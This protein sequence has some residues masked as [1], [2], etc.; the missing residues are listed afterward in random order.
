[1][2][3]AKRL[4]PSFPGKRFHFVLKLVICQVPINSWKF[5]LIQLSLYS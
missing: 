2:G 1:M 3:E 4:G 5:Q